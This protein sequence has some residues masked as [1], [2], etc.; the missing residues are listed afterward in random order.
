MTIY[1]DKVETEPFFKRALLEIGI[2]TD[3]KFHKLYTQAWTNVT[4]TLLQR[5]KSMQNI[6]DALIYNNTSNCLFIRGILSPEKLIKPPLHQT[7]SRIFL[8]DQNFTTNISF[9]PLTTAMSYLHEHHPCAHDRCILYERHSHS[10][11]LAKSENPYCNSYQL[12]NYDNTNTKYIERTLTRNYH[13]SQLLTYFMQYYNFLTEPITTFGVR[14]LLIA[15]PDYHISAL[16]QVLHTTCPPS[17]VLLGIS[18]SLALYS[19]QCPLTKTYQYL[20]RTLLFNTPHD[21]L[22]N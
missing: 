10:R 9:P 19:P 11:G 4:L 2:P 21:S 8:T 3:A 6:I 5:P 1:H 22:D 20:S 12:F 17:N 13:L 16:P 15:P 18:P 7:L 14:N